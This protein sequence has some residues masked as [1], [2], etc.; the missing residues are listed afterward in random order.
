MA[1]GEQTVFFELLERRV[2][3]QDGIGDEGS[4]HRLHLLTVAPPHATQQTAEH[5]R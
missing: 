1:H 5:E 2:V 4:V 3:I